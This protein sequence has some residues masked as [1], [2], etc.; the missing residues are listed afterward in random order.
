MGVGHVGI[1]KTSH[2][3]RSTSTGRV[4][5][6]TWS[7]LSTG[8]TQRE[9]TWCAHAPLQKEGTRGVLPASATI[10]ILFIECLGHWEQL[11]SQVGAL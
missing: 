1:A 9:T 3:L 6:R 10:K 2:W 5:T 8:V 11:T 4:V 7:S